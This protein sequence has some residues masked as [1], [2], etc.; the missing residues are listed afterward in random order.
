MWWWAVIFVAVGLLGL[1]AYYL[2]VVTEG[3]YLGRRMVIWLYDLTA[4]RYDRIK[5]FE[6]V[7]EEFF[8]IRPLLGRL[9]PV[10]NPLLLDVATGTGRLPYFLLEYPHFNGRVV[11]LDASYKML[12]GAAG[13]LRPY[14]DKGRAGLVRQYAHH[15][16]FADDCFDVVTCLE[17]LEFFPKDGTVLREMV[18]VLKPGGTLL[19]TRRK[20]V[21]GKAFVGRY[22]D[23]SQFEAYLQ[24]F[25]LQEVYTVPWQED[26]DQVYGRKPA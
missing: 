21:W 1:A 25:G 13:K 6:P 9:Q 24:T 3:L 11:G 18:R 12:L 14:L 19:V 5:A 20:G 22:R 26:Y 10:A 17:A 23:V 2:L 7:Y 4:H 15:L 16:P 8:L